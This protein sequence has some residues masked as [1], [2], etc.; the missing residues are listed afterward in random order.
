MAPAPPPSSGTRRIPINLFNDHE[1]DEE[2][3]QLAD[4]NEEEFEKEVQVNTLFVYRDDNEDEDIYND[5]L[6]L[7]STPG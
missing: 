6:N 2:V 7:S 1:D 4:D 5:D 3:D